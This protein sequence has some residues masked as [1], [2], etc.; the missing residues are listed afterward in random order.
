MRV[1]SVVSPIDPVRRHPELYLFASSGLSLAERLVFGLMAD[2]MQ[3]GVQD[4]RWDFDEGKHFVASSSNW[5][6]SDTNPDP[7]LF[8][9]VVSLTSA[10]ENSIRHEI[11]VA[12]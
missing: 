9:R 5:L 3:L 7:T 10:R 2:A 1:S 6:G 4:L 11:C 12:A 8:E